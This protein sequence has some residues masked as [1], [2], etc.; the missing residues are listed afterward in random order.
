VQGA[1]L[2]ALLVHHGHGLPLLQLH[3]AVLQVVEEGRGQATDKR[4]IV[5]TRENDED[6]GFSTGRGHERG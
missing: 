2:I 3:Q 4:A 6:T 5:K 1:N